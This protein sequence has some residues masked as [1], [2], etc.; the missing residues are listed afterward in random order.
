MPEDICT[1]CDGNGGWWT[2]DAYGDTGR[3]WRTCNDC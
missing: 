3:R 2:T 1:T